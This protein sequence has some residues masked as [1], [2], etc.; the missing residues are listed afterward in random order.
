MNR[1]DLKQSNRFL[2]IFEN[3][4]VVEKEKIGLSV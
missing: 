3:F 1:C 4:I 2:R